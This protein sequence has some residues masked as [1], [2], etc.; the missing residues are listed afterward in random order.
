MFRLKKSSFTTALLT[1]FVIGL[2]SP[3]FG[4]DK[5]S[6]AEEALTA[7]TV[8]FENRTN[9]RATPAARQFE[10][11][12][13][14]KLAENALNDVQTAT[15][16][17]QILRIFD[18]EKDKYGADIIVLGP[19]TNFGHVMAIQRIVAGYLE[20]AFEFKAEQAETMSLFLIYYNAEI[21]SRPEILEK[22]YSDAVIQKVDPKKAGIDK[23]YKN[24][25]GKTMLLI[26]LRKNVVRPDQADIDRDEIK[27]E[28]K[29]HTDATKDQKDELN[30]IDEQRKTDDQAKV[31]KKEQQIDEQK[32][33]LEKKEEQ[34]KKDIEDT[35][36]KLEE[37]RKDPV[38]N[39]VEIKKEEKKQEE[40]VKKQ[41]EVKKQQEDV[42]KQEEAVKQEKEEVKK[43]QSDNTSRQD[44]KKADS[45]DTATKAEEQKKNEQ[46][47]E[48]IANLEKEKEELKKQIEKKDEVSENVVLEKIL[49]MR[50]QPIEKGHYSNELW[51]VDTN[52]D[53]A[54][55]R[56]PFTKIC[57]REFVA[58]PDQ[59]VMVAGYAGDSH[60]QS[61]HFLVMLDQENLE[62]KKQSNESVYWNTPMILR[63]GKIYA[64]ESYKGQ[65]HLSRFNPDLSLDGRSSDGMSPSS[66]ITFFKD[67]IYV[68]GQDK[69]GKPTTIQ[70]FNR[71][72][73]KLIKTITPPK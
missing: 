14:T 71:G 54:L 18:A 1:M 51:Y 50:V 69:D 39:A 61:D 11:S 47:D 20:K 38:Q 22:S 21:R 25:S 28:T 56:S 72:D 63:D 34:I 31:E 58:V 46:K 7:P 23:S 44:E 48:Q 16:D 19:K 27:E 6:I 4:Q 66:E 68:T 64:I 53:D 30:K 40:Q 60:D 3:V 9:R 35:G 12:I 37:L 32:K 17:V 15:N 13:G 52:K 67:K 57:S 33:D 8:R 41:E 29:D 62:F 26:P 55:F 2:A 42:K 10:R 59:G 73:L 45:S 49:F 43:Q 5:P 65:Y 70:V 36:K 24:W